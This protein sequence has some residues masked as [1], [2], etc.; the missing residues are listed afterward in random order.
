MWSWVR[1]RKHSASIFSLILSEQWTI[2]SNTDKIKTIEN[3][4]KLQPVVFK[5]WPGLL[6]RWQIQR[7]CAVLKR[8]MEYQLVQFQNKRNVRVW[9]PCNW[10]KVQ[11]ESRQGG[12]LEKKG[13]GGKWGMCSLPPKLPHAIFVKGGALRWMGGGGWENEKVVMEGGRV[14]GGS[15]VPHLHHSTQTGG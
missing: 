2:R 1:W 12:G 5:F 7:H 8:S 6:H 15:L 9:F 13:E 11:K 4:I 14:E 3:T 10:A